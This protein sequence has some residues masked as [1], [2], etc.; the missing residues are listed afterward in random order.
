MWREIVFYLLAL[1]F[2]LAL[3]FCHDTF[4]KPSQEKGEHTEWQHSAS[5]PTLRR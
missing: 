1:V 5:P 4:I 2:V 3:S